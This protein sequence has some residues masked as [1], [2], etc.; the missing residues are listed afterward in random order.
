MFFD[1]DAK[2][3]EITKYLEIEKLS[4]TGINNYDL[5]ACFKLY[6]KSS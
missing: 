6:L 4:K 2:F 3:A 1:V 5:L